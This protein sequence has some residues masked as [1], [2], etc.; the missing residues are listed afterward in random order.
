M[1]KIVLSFCRMNPPT[2]GHER[3]VSAVV[4]TAKRINADHV[5]YLSQSHNKSTDPLEWNFKRRVCEYAFPGVNISKDISIRNPY[6]ALEHLKDQ[7]DKIIMVAGSDRID[8]YSKNFNKYSKNWNIELDFLS[9]GNR[10]SESNDID[11]VSSS[12]L[13]QYAR[14]KDKENFFRHLPNRLNENIKKIVYQNT[15][16][17]LRGV[18]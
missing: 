12:K 11:G 9:A 2:R 1:K 16:R 5:V 7:Y 8:E 10:I 15:I 4:E 14:D 6:L 3:V 17:G 18:K 13:R